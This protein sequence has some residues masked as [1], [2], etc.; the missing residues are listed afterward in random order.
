MK[1]SKDHSFDTEGAKCIG[2]IKDE[3][4]LHFHIDQTGFRD[5]QTGN[6]HPSS[7]FV[8]QNYGGALLHCLGHCNQGPLDKLQI[9]QKR[10]ARSTIYYYYYYYYL[11]LSLAWDHKS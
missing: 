1:F 11:L 10:A 2:I 3:K 4:Q 7:T 5:N 8:K 9:L 6:Q